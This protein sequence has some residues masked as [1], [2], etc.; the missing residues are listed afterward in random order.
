MKYDDRRVRTAQKRTLR[1][2]SSLETESKARS[3]MRSGASHTVISRKMMS[4]FG[5][6]G[7]VCRPS[8]RPRSPS[9]CACRLSS[10]EGLVGV[11]TPAALAR[12]L[13]SMTTGEVRDDEGAG[14]REHAK[15]NPLGAAHAAPELTNDDQRDF[16]RRAQSQPTVDG[17]SARGKLS[18]RRA[19]RWR[20]R[21]GARSSR[22]PRPVRAMASWPCR[23]GSVKP[24]RPG[25]EQR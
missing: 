14:E 5:A 15:D 24:A 21:P 17:R 20:L 2:W 6:D 13:P 12:L 1:C 9:R 3:A 4:E 19:P 10:T 23:R 11:A 8:S 18:P 22:R 16:R 25:R 7:H